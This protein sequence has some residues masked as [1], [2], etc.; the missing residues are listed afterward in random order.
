VEQAY[1]SYQASRLALKST[2]QLIDSASKA[3]EAIRA[4][5]GIGFA[6]MTSV[7]QALNQSILAANSYASSIREYNSAVAS[8]YR[9]SASW[10]G[11][12]LPLV[13]ERVT[14]LK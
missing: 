11:G 10:P 1:V 4:R 8:L 7:V 12:A 5:F 14:K 3:A 2:R 6:D 9:F 13:R